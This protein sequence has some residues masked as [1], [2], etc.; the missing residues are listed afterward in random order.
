MIKKLI[1]F[2]EEPSMEKALEKLLP[3]LVGD[4][5]YQ[6]ITFQCKDDLLKNAPARLK[7]YST[8][9]LETSRIL[10]LVDRD[11]DDCITLK[12]KLENVAASVGLCTKTNIGPG[13]KFSI[14]NRIVIEELEAW[15]FGDWQA[16]VD[17]YPGVPLTLPQAAKFRDPDAISGGTWEAMEKILNKAG[18]FKTGLRKCELANAVSAKMVP[19]RNMSRSFKAFIKGLEAA[20]TDTKSPDA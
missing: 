17:A 7:G 20:I 16:V 10:I 4:V 2:V 5:G 6:I 3:Q 14:V 1:V 8:W 19:D 9:L 18:Y 12:K 11:D 13:G 15:F